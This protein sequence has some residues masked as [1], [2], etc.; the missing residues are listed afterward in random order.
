MAVRLMNP[1]ELAMC[2]VDG[3]ISRLCGPVA[4]KSENPASV[5]NCEVL[6]SMSCV[7]VRGRVCVHMRAYVPACACLPVLYCVCLLL[8][9]A[10][11]GRL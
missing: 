10:C 7:G 4:M 8:Y 1:P 11:I 9:R 2:P 6:N 3:S 5:L